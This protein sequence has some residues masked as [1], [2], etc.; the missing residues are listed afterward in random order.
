MN[1]SLGAIAA[2]LIGTVL[3]GAAAVGLQETY[4]W[5]THGVPIIGTVTNTFEREECSS[6]NSGCLTNYYVSYRYSVT[7]GTRHSGTD[8]LNETRWQT[9]APGQDINLLYLPEK[10]EISSAA[11]AYDIHTVVMLWYAAAGLGGVLMLTGLLLLRN[12]KS[13]KGRH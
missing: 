13:E 7:V 4:H 2:L 5:Q 10:P 11:Y 6:N 3:A 12:N 1:R 9:Y 8:G